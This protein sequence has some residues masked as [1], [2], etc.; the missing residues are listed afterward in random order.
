[1]QFDTCTQSC[2]CMRHVLYFKH[3][4][5]IPPMNLDNCVIE[6]MTEILIVSLML[7]DLFLPFCYAIE[8]FEFTFSPQQYGEPFQWCGQDTFAKGTETS[9]Q[10]FRKGWEPSNTFPFLGQHFCTTNWPIGYSLFM[11]LPTYKVGGSYTFACTLSPCKIMYFSEF[12]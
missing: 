11:I 4:L 1:M 10:K 12:Y 7:R 2:T 9:A 6:W 3:T 5:R 8:I